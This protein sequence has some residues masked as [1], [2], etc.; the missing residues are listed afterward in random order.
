M[1]LC[2]SRAIFALFLTIST[3]AA[4][5]DVN[6]RQRLHAF[7][8]LPDWSGLW[9]QFNLGPSGAPTDAAEVKEIAA[10]SLEHPPYNAEWQAR[11]QV[12]EEQRMSR[13]EMPLCRLGF[14]ALMLNSPLMFEA[15]VTPEETTLIFS[16]R[17]T[18]H[19]YTDGRSHAP[20]DE[21]TLR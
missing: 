16:Q 7:A 15:I 11:Y 18:R 10:I 9:E 3:V 5:A 19:I 21:S 4:N 8:R 20:P 17:E 1:K 2:H 12:A 14:P 13:P 6:S